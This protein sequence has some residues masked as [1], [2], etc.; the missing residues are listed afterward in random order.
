MCHALGR[1][2]QVK[3]VADIEL[4][5]DELDELSSDLDSEESE[6]EMQNCGD[7]ETCLFMFQSFLAI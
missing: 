6:R 4:N 2:S 7:I 5:A 3:V 1:E